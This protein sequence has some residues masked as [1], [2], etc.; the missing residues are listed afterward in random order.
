MGKM[1]KTIHYYIY[2]IIMT[3]VVAGCEARNDFEPLDAE[4]RKWVN[5][6]EE[7]DLEGL[8]TLYKDDAVVSLHGQPA[9]FGKDAIRGYFAPRVGSAD[10]EFEL[11]YEVIEVHGN[12]GYVISKYWLIVKNNKNGK[13]Y[14]DAG[15]SLLVYKNE[16]GKWKIAADLD[17]TTPDVTWPSPNGLKY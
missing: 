17:Q 9:L 11:E 6:Y 16:N 4:G 8:M 2:V 14:Q 3:F 7:G 15:R 13:R 10:M 12:I 5:F 1:E